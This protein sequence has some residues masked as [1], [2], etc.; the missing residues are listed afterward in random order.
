[1]RVATGTQ[2]RSC[3]HI[4]NFDK[5]ENMVNL[6]KIKKNHT[7]ITNPPPQTP[8]LKHVH[9]HRSA[10]HLYNTHRSMLIP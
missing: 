8:F 5:N 10:L 9:Y 4:K 6:G 1:M 2:K 3:V 7:L